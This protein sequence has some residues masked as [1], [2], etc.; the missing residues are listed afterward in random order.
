MLSP[1]PED[2]ITLHQVLQHPWMKS[3]AA[4]CTN[5]KDESNSS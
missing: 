1:N 2:R 3:M 5:D 4:L